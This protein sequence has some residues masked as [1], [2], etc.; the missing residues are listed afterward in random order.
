MN[1][2]FNFPWLL[3]RLVKMNEMVINAQLAINSGEC[4]YILTLFGTH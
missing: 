1:G 2:I 4:Y 3:L